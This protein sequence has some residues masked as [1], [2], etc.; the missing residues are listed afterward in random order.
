MAKFKFVKSYQGVR[1]TTR[2]EIQEVQVRDYMTPRNQLITFSPNDPIGKVV[3]IML[4]KN[5]SGGPVVDAEGNLVGII[6]EGDCLKEVVKGK[7]SNT[8]NHAGIVADHMIE[9]IITIAP[10]TGI[11]EAANQFLSN[12]VRRFP[13]VS[14]GEL[15][16]MISQRDVLKAVENLKYQD[17]EQ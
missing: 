10:D 8:P 7:Y 12:R 9:K 11:L 13:V 1:A 6:S 2:P 16:G 15:L 4:S 5:I 14:D 17:Y 3:S